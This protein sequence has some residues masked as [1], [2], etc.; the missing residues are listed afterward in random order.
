MKNKVGFLGLAGT[1]IFLFLACAVVMLGM[2]GVINLGTILSA[3]TPRASW[4]EWKVTPRRTLLTNEYD[5]SGSDTYAIQGRILS[6]WGDVFTLYDEEG[7]VVMEEEEIKKWEH[8]DSFNR[9]AVVRDGDGREV[10]IFKEDKLGDYVGGD[11]WR[12]YHIYELR[13]GTPI[14]VGF[15]E[16]ELA[17]LPK[18]GI[19]NSDGVLEYTFAWTNLTL[20]GPEYTVWQEQEH[21]VVPHEYAVLLAAIRSAIDEAESNDDSLFED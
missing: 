19:Y 8:F 16:S 13:G 21:P 14:E 6:A 5:V 17:V 10:A 3:R 11:Y 2:L 9:I 1:A 12:T 15:V 20:G 7:N 18:Y 4:A